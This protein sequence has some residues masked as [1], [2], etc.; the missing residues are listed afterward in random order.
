MIETMVAG[1]QQALETNN[2]ETM[3]YD[4]Y[5]PDYQ[6]YPGQ[7]SPDLVYDYGPVTVPMVST[8]SSPPIAMP[9]QVPHGHVVQQIVDESGTLRH[10]ILSP[11][12]PPIVPMPTHFGPGPA[13]GSNQPPQPFFTPQGLPPGY[14]PFGNPLQPGM[15]GHVPPQQGHSPP[16]NFHKDERTQKQ[17]IKLKKKLEQ[18]QLGLQLNEQ[19][20]P[21]VSPR[22]DLVNGTRG[23]KKGGMSSVGTSEDGEESSSVQDEDEEV[24]LIIDLLSTIKAPQVTELNCRSALLQ[25]WP[26]DCK[27]TPELEVSEASISYEVLLSDKGKEGKY[28]S[29]YSGSALSCRIQDLK[30]GVEY[31]VCVTGWLEGLMGSASE[32]SLFRTPPCEPDTPVKLKL[33]S[34]T[35]TSLQLRW[36]AVADNGSPITHYLL[37]SWQESSKEWVEVYRG[38]GKQSN[39]SKLQPATTYKFR[40]AAVNECGQSD[41]SDEVVFCTS[42]SPPTAPAP[43]VLQEAG[44][45]SLTLGWEQ[46]PVDDEFTLQMDDRDT[47]HGFLPVYNG[48][49]LSHVCNDL[50]R[51]T[52]YKFRLRAQNEEGSSQWSEEV[53]YRTLPGRPAP[54]SRPFVKG[55]VHAHYFKVKWEPPTD[56][57]G[58]DITA[59]TVQLKKNGEFVSVYG[60]LETE[61]VL[62]R[63]SPGTV[64]EVR[65]CCEGAGGVS[66][67]SDSLI[68][69]TE[70]TCPGQCAPPR[71]HGKPRPYS[72]SLRWNYPEV[73]GGAPVS[74]CEILVRTQN[75]EDRIAYRGKDT[76]CTVSS[77]SPGHSYTFLLRANNRVGAG[78]WSEPLEV[79]SG[80]APPDTPAA[81]QCTPRP[82]H[83]VS[84]CWP[85]PR[86]N[87]ASITDYRLEMGHGTTPAFTTVYQ[88]A[89]TSCD[90]RS[91][92]PASLCLFRLQACNV[93]GWSDF[94]PVTSLVSPPAVPGPP[95]APRYTA[96]PN[97]LK[98]SWG[99]AP[100]HGSPVTHYCVEVAD[101]SIVT[102]EQSCVVDNLAP[103]TT[104]KVRLKA[105]NSVGAGPLSAAVKASTLPLPPAPP[106]LSCPNAG[107]NYLKLKWG[108]GKNP[109]FTQYT[110]QMENPRLAEN[111]LQVV[112]QGTS[113]CCKVNR[114]QEQTVYR[115]CISAA[116]DAGQ[117]PDSSF[118]EFSTT[119]APPPSLK[120][121]RVSEVSTK[122]C[123]VEWPPCKPLASDPVL[124]CLQL[125]RLRDQIYKQVYRGGD[126]K[127]QLH[128]L[129]P[130]A[131]YCVRVCA[132]RQTGVGELAGA[133]SPT[134]TFAT[135]APHSTPTHTT[136]SH[137]VQATTHKPLTD[138][139]WAL[140]LLVAFAILA[141]LFAFIVQLFMY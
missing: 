44:V 52:A 87:G 82:G 104:Y 114:L 53:S 111:G 11:Q 77:L 80:N 129:E 46:R 127:T 41:W 31:S 40:L 43:P 126:T 78:A 100:D 69:P 112:Y 76:E 138:T 67:Y 108:D 14:P 37:Q 38:K 34:R 4:Y 113:H 56:R 139:Q 130:G 125:S 13:A 97:S 105:V 29:I 6:H 131:D 3:Y 1:G 58:T 98:L 94:S 24:N 9:V 48:K 36:N 65:V 55:R 50:R 86:C 83:V 63:L 133:F 70:A 93:A 15:L 102:E 140:I 30:P 57:G 121:P 124:Y 5:P 116:N 26:P 137:Q 89:Q 109:Q 84:C 8:N 90:V 79:R 35:R 39:L 7:G 60:G 18:K 51:H 122:G 33:V 12:H 95:P 54:P 123:S 106:L 19:R 2:D 28:K 101:R 49:D 62:D 72:V 10:V 135:P 61:C 47:G 59:Y 23:G 110:V 17:Y 68:V 42:D 119:I 99:S 64:Y 115:F 128:D 88:G 66:E 45:T 118:Y 91:I 136:K 141:F 117:G 20:T 27:T 120:A 85:E 81:P 32:P 103:A 75:V 16:P 73:D 71:L 74:E 21:P 107:H 134:A 25:W 92:P 96:T 22:K 132:V